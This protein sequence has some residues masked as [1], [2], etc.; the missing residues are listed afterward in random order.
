MAEAELLDQESTVTEQGSGVLC[1]RE[2]RDRVNLGIE[3][4]RPRDGLVRG[5]GVRTVFP[6]T[7]TGCLSC[8]ELNGGSRSTERTGHPYEL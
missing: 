2:R 5:G 1:T 4:V 6:M 8:L 7:R 3:A